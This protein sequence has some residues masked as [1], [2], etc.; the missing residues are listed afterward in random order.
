MAQHLIFHHSCFS[1]DEQA[2]QLRK[3]EDGG[4]LGFKGSIK[5]VVDLIVSS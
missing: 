3:N 4:E 5:E 1:R 2:A